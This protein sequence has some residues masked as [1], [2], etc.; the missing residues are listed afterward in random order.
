MI[1]IGNHIPYSHIIEYYKDHNLNTPIQIFTGSPMSFHRKHKE[2]SNLIDILRYI[3]LYV[4]SS[5]VINIGNKNNS[6]DIKSL[7][8]LESDLL[9]SNELSAKGLVIHVSKSLNI[10]PEYALINMFKDICK[11]LSFIKSK[12]IKTKLLLETPAGQGTELLSKLE[13]FISFCKMIKKAKYGKLFSICIDTC[14]IFALGYDPDIYIQEVL[15]N[16]L[17]IDLVHLNDSKT[18]KGSRL[19]RHAKIFTGKI[20]KK[21]LLNCIKICNKHNIDMIYEVK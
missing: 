21:N 17:K 5:Y 12:N 6:I 10:D 11:L 4:H 8:Y 18:A 1:T 3:H 14:H 19:D 7:K 20:P 2:Y 16:G 15:N 9:I 13:D